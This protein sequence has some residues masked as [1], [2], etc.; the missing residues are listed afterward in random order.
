MKY[1]TIKGFLYLHPF[2]LRYTLTAN[3]HTLTDSS[4][5]SSHY[6]PRFVLALVLKYDNNNNNAMKY[7]SLMK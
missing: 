2:V 4:P 1:K 3:S 7:F 5:E 6:C